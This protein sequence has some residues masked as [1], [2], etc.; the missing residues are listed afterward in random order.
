MENNLQIVLNLLN[1]QELLGNQ[2]LKI[3][4]VKELLYDVDSML[5]NKEEIEIK[6]NFATKE[7]REVFNEIMSKISEIKKS[8]DYPDSIFYM[9]GDK[10]YMERNLKTDI[11][12]IKY[13]NFWSIFE[14]RFKL[15]DNEISD[16]LR[17]L[18]E[19]HSK[20][21]INSTVI[22][23]PFKVYRLEDYF[24]CNINK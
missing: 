20:I 4:E 13:S 19:E 11:F 2:S 22:F 1:N 5:N 7:Q 24:K 17:C 16:L 18:L 10:V 6:N 9:I 14:T 3:K 15:N 8:V 23:C 12:Y 21:K